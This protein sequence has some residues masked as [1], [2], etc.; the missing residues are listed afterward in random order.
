MPFE[1]AA[2]YRFNPFDLTK[3]WPHARLPADHG[4]ADG[5]RP[6]PGQLLRPDRAG[7]V[8]AVEHGARASARQPGQDAAGPAVQLPRHPPLP[9]RRQ[10]PAAAGQ[11]AAA[12]RC[13]ATTRTGAMRYANPGRPG[14]RPEL[15]RRS[16]SPD[17]RSSAADPSWAV[18]RRD[19]AAAYTL[20]AEDDDFGQAGTLVREVLDDAA[21]GRLVSNVAGPRSSRTWSSRCCPGSFD[22]WRKVDGDSAR[23]SPKELGRST[24]RVTRRPTTPRSGPVP[25]R[26]GA[27]RRR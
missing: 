4:R 13:T 7:R 25:A 20:H 10:L 12:R 8:R 21:A 16:G 6:Q 14:L 5:A 27:D 19:R 17:P 24:P 15:L 2:D 9:H 3:V 18:D 11:P 23:G 26:V 22:Y 1:D